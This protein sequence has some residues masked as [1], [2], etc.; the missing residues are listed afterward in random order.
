[1][2]LELSSGII[3]FEAAAMFHDTDAKFAII[4]SAHEAKSRRKYKLLFKKS[5]VISVMTLKKYRGTLVHG[6]AH[7]FPNFITVSYSVA[8]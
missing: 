6:T 4:D 7:L 2:T 8:L 1:M 3:V 5:T